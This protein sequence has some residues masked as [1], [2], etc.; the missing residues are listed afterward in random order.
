M[1]MIVLHWVYFYS[2]LSL[3]TCTLEV[4]VKA[5]DWFFMECVYLQYSVQWKSEWWVMMVFSDFMYTAYSACLY[6]R[7][8]L[9]ETLLNEPAFLKNG[10]SPTGYRDQNEKLVRVLSGNVWLILYLI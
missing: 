10:L 9:W 8:P 5:H 7:K 6:Q 2:A 4:F 3:F 1:D